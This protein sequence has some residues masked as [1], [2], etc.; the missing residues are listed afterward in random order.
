MKN[1]FLALTMAVS[2]AS[3]IAADIPPVDLLR[4]AVSYDRTQP[5]A[6]DLDAGDLADFVWIPGTGVY[7]DYS[8]KQYKYLKPTKMFMLDKFNN[9]EI[10]V[11]DHAV[12]EL[13]RY[14]IFRKRRGKAVLFSLN[15]TIDE[16]VKDPRHITGL[17]LN[18]QY[19]G[20]IVL[21][22]DAV[23]R[24]LRFFNLNDSDK[25]SCT[26]GKVY[27]PCPR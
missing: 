16:I 14:G 17:M 3:A 21:K 5:L 2:V 10:L 27:R 25:F 26:N 8:N 24:L 13:E 6:S 9:R 4:D 7:D 23:D 18:P 19:P 15:N 12:I 20:V 22:T 11:A 1:I